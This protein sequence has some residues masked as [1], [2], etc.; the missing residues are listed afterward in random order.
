M[1]SSPVFNI[2]ILFYYLCGFTK[3]ILFWLVFSLKLKQI[4][5]NKKPTRALISELEMQHKF[6]SSFDRSSSRMKRKPYTHWKGDY[7]CIFSSPI[8]TL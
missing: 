7:R 4:Y 3:L 2:Y 1:G 5:N 6:L 8:W